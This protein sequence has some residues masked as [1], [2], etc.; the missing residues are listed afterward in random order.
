MQLTFEQLPDAVSRLFLKLEGIEQLLMQSNC[1]A[2]TVSEDPIT[3]QQ[4]ADF[5]KLSVSTLYMLVSRSQIPYMKKGK[6]L[7]FSKKELNEWIKTGR[8]KTIAE[9]DIEADGYLSS[10]KKRRITL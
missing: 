5:I 1:P 2:P 9:M 10:N 3:I 6:R 8:K 7:Y 4:A